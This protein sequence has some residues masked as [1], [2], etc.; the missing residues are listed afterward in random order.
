MCGSRCDND[1]PPET[2][3][4]FPTAFLETISQDTCPVSSWNLKKTLFCEVASPPAN[5]FH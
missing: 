4:E 5:S 3:M 2:G 1:E